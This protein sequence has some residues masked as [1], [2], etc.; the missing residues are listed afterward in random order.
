MKR[1]DENS[2]DE[3]QEK[4]QEKEQEDLAQKLYLAEFH[5]LSL[6]VQEKHAVRAAQQARGVHGDDQVKV[7][8][9][10]SRSRADVPGFS[11][12]IIY[13]KEWKQNFQVSV[14]MFPQIEH[15][16]ILRE[17]LGVY[18]SV[19]FQCIGSSS[20]AMD[21]AWELLDKEFIRP[22]IVEAMLIADLTRLVSTP[23]REETQFPAIV[24]KVRE[25]FDRLVSNRKMGIFSLDTILCTWV[26]NMPDSVSRCAIEIMVEREDDWNFTT[27]LVMAEKRVERIEARIWCRDSANIQR[28]SAGLQPVSAECH[29]SISGEKNTIDAQTQVTESEIASESLTTDS[30]MD[31]NAECMLCISQSHMTV[32]CMICRSAD[33]LRM[34][35]KRR[36]ICQLCGLSG[37]KSFRCPCYMTHK[38]QGLACKSDI[39]DSQ[40]PHSSV[41]CALNRKPA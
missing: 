5:G 4:G 12:D 13:Y 11:G 10:I 31:S 24:M 7:V 14:S 38:D 33:E 34:L 26:D 30:V 9:S 16:E 37:H 18:K 3:D 28:K 27:I 15:M 17:K 39:C 22:R 2:L 29:P 1:V 6:E 36:R 20:G 19:V 40:K 21:K 41:F 23:C 32:D 25:R 8:Y 35:V